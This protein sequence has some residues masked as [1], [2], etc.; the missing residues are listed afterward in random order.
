MFSSWDSYVVSW[1]L[2]GL[3][4][5]VVVVGSSQLIEA[6]QAAS[7]SSVTGGMTACELWKRKRV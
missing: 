5:E 3:R 2:S 7:H 4:E 6:F 1:E